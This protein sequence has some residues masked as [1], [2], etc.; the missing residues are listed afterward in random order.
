[1]AYKISK[2]PNSKAY[3]EEIAD[4][5]E[6]QAIRNP[7]I[8]VSQT[9]ITQIL[10]KE[11]DEID[12]DGIESEDDIVD[13]QNAEAF[14]ELSKRPIFTSG[15]YPF[16]FKKYSIKIQD[17]D[18]F[19]KDAYLFLLLCAR[20]NMNNHRSYNGVDATLLF[21]K[22]CAYVAEIFF[23]DNA[24]SIV[25]GTAVPGTFEDKI[26]DLITH[27]GEGKKFSNPNNTT[28]PQKDDGIDVVV[29]KEFSDKRIGKLIGFGQC[30]TGTTSWR[31]GIRK[32][33]SSDFCS[34]WFAEHPIVTPVQIAFICD[35]MNENFNFYTAQF[36]YLV[37]NRFRILELLD[38]DLPYELKTD[39]KNWLNGALPVLGIKR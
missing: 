14:Q 8:F 17:G 7:D 28:P 10:S 25:F 9:S 21:E 19:F 35:T 22:I 26:N 12:H 33:N 36:R 11:L 18:S 6:V 20:F 32:L 4:F 31:D 38:E 23:G 30:K 13:S 16:D 1:M 34:N 39:M 15:K 37:F 27:I 24:K 29:W 3:K 2:I 5:W